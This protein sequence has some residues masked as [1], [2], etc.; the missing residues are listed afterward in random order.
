M[1]AGDQLEVSLQG[2]AVAYATIESVEQ[3]RATILI[4]ATRVVM[5]IATTLTPETPAP[6]VDR[7]TTV[8]T[9]DPNASAKSELE[10]DY[11]S[12]FD[13]PGGFA[14]APEP[15]TSLKDMDFDSS[16]ID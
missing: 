7:T 8:L 5:G 14:N 12:A 13:G 1:K 10:A 9:E 11:D 15:V 6:E 3:D 16:A 2:I 4:P